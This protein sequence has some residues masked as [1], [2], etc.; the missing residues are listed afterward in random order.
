VGERL[1]ESAID[2]R[3]EVVGRLT[4]GWGHRVQSCRRRHAREQLI[5]VLTLVVG[6]RSDERIDTP[7][8]PGAI[9]HE[10]QRPVNAG[11]G[12]RRERG[13]EREMA[14]V[15]GAIAVARA[16]I[17]AQC[18][19]LEAEQGGAAERCVGQSAKKGHGR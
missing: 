13:E 18:R 17:P 15:S 10:G 8:L 11:A 9:L 12:M 7:S 1:R 14:T 2:A 19:V 5:A 3:K 4:R 16:S 6:R